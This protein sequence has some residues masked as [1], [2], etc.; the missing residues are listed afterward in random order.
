[1]KLG[2]VS[3]AIEDLTNVLRQDPNSLGPRILLGKAYKIQQNYV[4]AEEAIGYAINLDSSQPDIYIERGD[5][6]CR[7]GLKHVPEA[8]RGTIFDYIRC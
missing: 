2:H 3:K 4:A 6:R 1:M 8:I 7:M 5:I